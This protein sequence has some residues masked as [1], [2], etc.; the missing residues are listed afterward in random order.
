MPT[1]KEIIESR[2]HPRPIGY[3]SKPTKIKP[4]PGIVRQLGF[5]RPDVRADSY[6]YLELLTDLDL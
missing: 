3:R 6:K 1:E 5:E 2:T 4:E